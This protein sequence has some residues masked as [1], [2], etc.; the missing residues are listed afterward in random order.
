MKN[1]PLALPRGSVRAIL[2]VGLVA[3]VVAGFLLGKIDGDSLMQLATMAM[4]F[5]F[6]VRP[7]ISH[8]AE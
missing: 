7:P 6:V 5:Y 8:A 1:E 4:A 2:A 3:S